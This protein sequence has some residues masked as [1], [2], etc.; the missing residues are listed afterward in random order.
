MDGWI[1]HHAKAWTYQS[2]DS[3][4]KSL[5]ETSMT[6]YSTS[7]KALTM[8]DSISTARMMPVAALG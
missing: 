6:G 5:T 3:H 2:I 8:T 1:W 7:T 4:V